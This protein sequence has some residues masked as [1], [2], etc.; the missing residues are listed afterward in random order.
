MR[1]VRS[2]ILASPLAFLAIAGAACGET[3]DPTLATAPDG[4]AA[5]T[6]DGAGTPTPGADASAP[7]DAAVEAAASAAITP[8]ATVKLPNTLNPYG[9]VWAS[10]GNVYVSG[11]RLDTANANDRELAV[12][13]FSAAGVLDTTFGTGGVLTLAAAGDEASF[14]IAEIEAGSFVVHYTAAGKVW[15]VKLTK[16][17]GG[18]FSFGTPKAVLFGWA[19]ADFAAWPLNP[20]TPAYT[21]W[22]LAIDRSVAGTPKIVVFASG[23]PQ[24][25]AAGVQRTDNDRWVTRLL[26]DADF[27]PDPSFNGGAA[28]SLDATGAGS[29][30]SGSRRGFVEADGKIVSAGYSAF[31]NG[32]GIVL[33]R[34]TPTG[35][36]DQTF[37]FGASSLGQT[38]INPFTTVSGG[39]AEAY[40]IGR[41]SSGRYVTT[42]Y[43]VTAWDEPSVGQDLLTTGILADGLDV[44]YGKL[45]AF[46]IQSETDNTAGLGKV[47]Y[48]D[49]GRDLV[50]L[51]D[52]RTVHVGCYDDN[53]A[54]FVFTKDGRPDTSFGTGGVLQYA[55]GFA[56]YKAAISPDRTRIAATAQS[57]LFAPATEPSSLLAILKVGP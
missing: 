25:V 31:D 5:T 35:A 38:R 47:P 45:G 53:A 18:V 8:L 44:T 13:R 37:G 3:D 39:F 36:L 28:F 26:N 46:A 41:Q 55:H 24:K 42:G 21:S 2:L 27:T 33:I 56:F 15:L 4:G 16:D 54:F 9:I 14:D 11:A 12:W 51:P 48:R 32:N 30:D 34:L 50:V 49:Q 7:G 29:N 6:P 40:G 10:D 23:A 52:D 17:A 43:G 20:A 57:G 22:G 1:S 19:D